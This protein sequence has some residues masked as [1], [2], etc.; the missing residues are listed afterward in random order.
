MWKLARLNTKFNILNKP[1]N[2]RKV[3]LSL[4][5]PNQSTSNQN[6][7]SLM[8]QVGG[9]ANTARTYTIYS[10][11]LRDVELYFLSSIYVRRISN[12]FFFSKN[13]GINSINRKDFIFPWCG[14]KE[15]LLDWK[16][17]KVRRLIVSLI[18]IRELVITPYKELVKAFLSSSLSFIS[19]IWAKLFK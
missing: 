16:L 9:L 5:T 19:C 3:F 7:L 18:A 6:S 12:S 4:V 17:T 8:L 2:P 14:K 13:M 15:S 1:L 11:S 10:V